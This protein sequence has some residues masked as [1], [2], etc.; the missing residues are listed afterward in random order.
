M[1]DGDKTKILEKHNTLRRKVAQ[2]KED[3]GPDGAQPA[4]ANMMKL[5]KFD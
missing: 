1:T 3:Q 5:V 2:G 4:A